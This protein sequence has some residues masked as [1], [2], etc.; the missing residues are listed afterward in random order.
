MTYNNT[1]KIQTQ[2][3]FILNDEDYMHNIF[4]NSLF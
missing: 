1:A 4:C 2:K 3:K